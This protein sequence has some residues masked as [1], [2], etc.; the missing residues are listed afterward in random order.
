MFRQI[1]LRVAKIM[2]ITHTTTTAEPDS[3]DG[4]ISSD[5]WNE[6]HTIAAETVTASM[7]SNYRAQTRY[8]DDFIGNHGGKWV[9]QNNGTATLVGIAGEADHPG[10]V[11]VSASSASAI[12]ALTLTSTSSVAPLLPAS[13]FDITF[14]CR[15][16]QKD[17][18]SGYRI[19]LFN[20]TVAASV[21]D[22][23]CFNAIG[24]TDFAGICIN[25]GVQTSTAG[26]FSYTAAT[27]YRFRIRRVDASTI[28]FSVNG[29]T[30]QTVT[31]NVPTVALTPAAYVYRASSGTKTLDTD[32][33]DLLITGLTR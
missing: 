24:N 22:V 15:P 10:I 18:D 4:K 8:I 33:F 19:G 9:L 14:I 6:A 25:G 7:L 17:A 16:N 13:N 28:G 20:A 23:I 21:N 32:L 11:R 3:G 27:W 2:A 12:A 5:A 31:T 29:G 1:S 30:E 26:T